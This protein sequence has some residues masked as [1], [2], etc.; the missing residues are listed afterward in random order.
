MISG[1]TKTIAAPLFFYF[2]EEAFQIF[3]ACL[4]SPLKEQFPCSFNGEGGCSCFARAIPLF[5]Y[6][7]GARFCSVG[8]H[9]LCNPYSVV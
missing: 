5:F 6:L 9:G 3:S 1:C 8:E 2:G 7:E 4:S